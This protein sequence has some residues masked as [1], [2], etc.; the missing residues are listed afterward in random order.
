MVGITRLQP[1]ARIRT[2]QR[3]PRP[4]FHQTHEGLARDLLA[5]VGMLE[6]IP[7]IIALSKRSIASARTLDALHFALTAFLMENGAQVQVAS[8]DAR[9]LEGARSCAYRFCRSSPRGLS[10]VGAAVARTRFYL[11]D[12]GT[13]ILKPILP[14]RSTLDAMVIA[15]QRS[16]LSRSDH[17]SQRHAKPGRNH[18]QS[19]DAVIAAHAT[20]AARRHAF[21]KVRAAL[22]QP[23]LPM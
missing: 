8:Y 19:G 6:L 1:A 11:R 20:T 3:A 13:E 10:R 2:A 17:G 15:F 22:Q 14:S 23:A 21:S 5:R 9:L 12:A 4:R 18:E 7:E 16:A